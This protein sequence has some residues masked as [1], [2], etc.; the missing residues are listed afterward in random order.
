[1][2]ASV[3]RRVYLSLGSNIDREKNILACLDAL[4]EQFGELI[5]SPVY[6]SE[7]VGFT[8]DSFY[9]LV[10]GIDSALSV[11]ELAVLMRE[12]EYANKRSRAGPKF[13]P[14]TLDIDILT[15]GELTGLID[16]VALPRDEVIENAFVLLPLVDIAGDEKHPLSGK[17]YRDIAKN[18]SGGEQRLWRIDFSWQGKIISKVE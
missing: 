12:I 7:A 16:G 2:S 13:G 15:C 8:G 14:R 3:L 6:E 17:A 9:N 1:M 18:F 10:V 11:G 4:A 5:I